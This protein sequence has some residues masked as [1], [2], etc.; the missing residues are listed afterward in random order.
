MADR[1]EFP[2]VRDLVAG[3]CGR[4]VFEEGDLEAGIWS[5]GPAQGLIDDVRPSAKSWSA[6]WPKR[7][8]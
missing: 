5:V 2:D 1:G 4:R 7:T 6:P 3:S 8:P